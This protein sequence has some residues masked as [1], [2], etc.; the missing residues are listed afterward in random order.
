MLFVFG[1]LCLAYYVVLCVT[2]KKWNS[3][4]S[5]FWLVAGILFVVCSDRLQVPAQA[6][7]LFMLIWKLSFAVVFLF[8]VTECMILLRMLPNAKQREYDYIIVLGAH[9]EGTRITDSLERR[10]VK[11]IEYLERCPFA[12]VIVSGGMG[13]GE[14]IT[15]A[16]AMARYLEEHGIA[17]SRIIREDK[18][19]TTKENLKFSAEYI[20]NLDISVGIVSNNFHMYRACCYARRLGYRSAYPLAAGCH[21]ILFVNYMVRECLAVWKMWIF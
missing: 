5:R 3:T 10:L 17:G 1:I 11:A 13:K 4:F 2:L 8:L 21:P 15:E 7:S 9:V 14:D 19:R 6:G 16:E 12:R 18:S 20:G